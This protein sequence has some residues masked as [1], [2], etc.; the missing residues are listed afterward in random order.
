[1]GD[2][3]YQ[4]VEQWVLDTAAGNWSGWAAIGLLLSGWLVRFMKTRGIPALVAWWTRSE[5]KVEAAAP[6]G[7]VPS[8]SP[9]RTEVSS[10]V[11]LFL[12]EQQRQNLSVVA[13]LHRHQCNH[14]TE[15]ARGVMDLQSSLEGSDLLKAV[16][17]MHAQSGRATIDSLRVL[18][19]GGPG[20][21]TLSP[22]SLQGSQPALSEL[23]GRSVEAYKQAVR[24]AGNRRS[25]DLGGRGLGVGV[26][27]SVHCGESKATSGVP[28]A[29][30]VMAKG[31]STEDLNTLLRQVQ[32]ARS[33]LSPAEQ[34][35]AQAGRQVVAAQPS[36]K[37]DVPPQSCCPADVISLEIVD[38][39]A[40]NGSIGDPGD[41][42]KLADPL[43]LGM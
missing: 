33:S 41:E 36:L 1:M 37:K 26:P 28:L 27:P 8:E 4:T 25:S 30:P 31:E 34:L 29:T 43:H 6:A 39:D 35:A 22:V 42:A 11:L 15:V 23:A 12:A 9:A 38:L 24:D 40:L 7:H 10:Q 21:K 13:D 18:T 5:K 3:W 2:S 14:L 17:Q 20:R 32:S 19:D 16:T